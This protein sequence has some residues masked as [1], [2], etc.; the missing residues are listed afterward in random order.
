MKK[1]RGF[2]KLAQ[3][4]TT[5][6]CISNGVKVEAARLP[7]VQSDEGGCLEWSVCE[8]TGRLLSCIVGEHL[9]AI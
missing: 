5:S 8:C 7:L 9:K 6:Q 1:L 4:C 2:K 3:D